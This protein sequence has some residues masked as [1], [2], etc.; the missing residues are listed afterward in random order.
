MARPWVLLPTATP[1]AWGVIDN[2][3]K[4]LHPNEILVL[5][6][7]YLLEEK[8]WHGPVVRNLATTHMLDRVARAHGE[9]C[10]EVPVGFK[11][12]S[13]KM[14]EHDAIMAVNPLAV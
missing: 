5:L 14:A 6:Y 10:Y 12:V 3:G 1:T 7:E 11:W 4:F 13:S 9:Q 8:G 2:T